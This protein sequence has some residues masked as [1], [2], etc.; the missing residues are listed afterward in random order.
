MIKEEWIGKTITVYLAGGWEASGVVEG[1]DKDSFTLTMSDLIGQ[2]GTFTVDGSKICMVLEWD[3]T[4]STEKSEPEK[5]PRYNIPEEPDAGRMGDAN[6]FMGE[7]V[8]ENQYG[9]FI[10]SD[11]LVASDEPNYDDDFSI[12]SFQLENPGSSKYRREDRG[13]SE[14]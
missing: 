2:L 9:S 6:P 4:V 10:P 12:S 7:M 8:E 1:I 14:K 13:D 11:M 3:E 5:G